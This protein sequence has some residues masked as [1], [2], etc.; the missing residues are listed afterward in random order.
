MAEIFFRS[1]RLAG[2]EAMVPP[3]KPTTTILP[4]HARL[5]GKRR[6][7]KRDAHSHPLG[8]QLLKKKE[9]KK[10]WQ[11]CRETGTLE[12]HCWNRKMVQPLWTTVRR[13]LQKLKIELPCDRAIPSGAISKGTESSLD[14]I[15]THPCVYSSTNYNHQDRKATLMSIS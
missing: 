1:R 6:N 15:F 10:C 2:T 9:E 13:C 7:V 5:R 12:H 8:W 11:G 4:S 14:E 3:A